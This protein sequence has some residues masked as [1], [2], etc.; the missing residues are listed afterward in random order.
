[1]RVIPDRRSSLLGAMPTW[2]VRFTGKD[3]VPPSCFFFFW[4]FT[5]THTFGFIRSIQD[6]QRTVF[7]QLF[8]PFVVVCVCWCARVGPTTSASFDRTTTKGSRDACAQHTRI[9]FADVLESERGRKVPQN[10]VRSWHT[11]VR[12][13]VSCRHVV[14]LSDRL[15]FLCTHKL[16]GT[17]FRVFRFFLR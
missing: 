13:K 5:H 3:M 17:A 15:N 6:D 8:S 9:R 4:Q 2:F 14:S 16:R 7:R 12:A 10:T 1:M 11:L